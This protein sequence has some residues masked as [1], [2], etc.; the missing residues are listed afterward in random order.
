MFKDAFN[1]LS[2]VNPH[3][4]HLKVLPTFQDKLQQLLMFRCLV[5]FLVILMN[6][7]LFVFNP[8]PMSVIIW[9]YFLTF[10]SRYFTWFTRSSFCVFDDTL[11]YNTTFLFLTIPINLSTSSSLNLHFPLCYW[12]YVSFLNVSSKCCIGYS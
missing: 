3:L 10:S 6:S 7:F 5:S 4:T 9:S 11:A 12:F 1:C 2:R 8:D